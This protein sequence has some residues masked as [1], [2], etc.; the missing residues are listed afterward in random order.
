VIGVATAV[1]LVAGGGIWYWRSGGSSD[2]LATLGAAPSAPAMALPIALEGHC[3]VSLSTEM[4]WVPGHVAWNAVYDGQL[5]LFASQRHQEVFLINPSVYGPALSGSDIVEAAER[6]MQVRG[7]RQFGVNHGGRVY[8]FASEQNLARF[9]QAPDHFLMA[10]QQ[11]AAAPP[12]EPQIARGPL[13]VSL[14]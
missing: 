12:A 2:R 6:R 13:P 1:L 9:A 7:H 8:L 14:R 10:L 3:P 4:R 11:P 5:Y